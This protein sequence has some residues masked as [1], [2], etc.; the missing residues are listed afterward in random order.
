MKLLTQLVKKELSV[1]LE[2]EPSKTELEECMAFVKGEVEADE[3]CTLSDVSLLIHDFV[4][5]EYVKCEHCGCWVYGPDADRI[6]T[7]DLYVCDVCVWEYV[8]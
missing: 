5:N 4:E 8:K 2:H 3:N 1:K 7:T 6:P